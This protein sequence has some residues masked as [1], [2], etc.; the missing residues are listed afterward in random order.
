MSME[1]S[2]SGPGI[3][4]AP[5]GAVKARLSDVL[6]TMAFDES[7]PTISLGDILKALKGK[8]F[9]GLMFVFALP[10]LAPLPP[11][12]ST[13]LGIPLIFLASQLM[14]GQAPWLPAV[15]RK[16]SVG[17]LDLVRVVE[18]TGPWLVRFERLLR[19]RL[20]FLFH[21]P[22]ENLI[23]VVCL[24]LA[25]IL[26]LPV[27]L[28]NLPPAVAICLMS[29]GLVERDGVFVLAGVAAGIVACAA[30]AGA[31]LAVLKGMWLLLE[32]WSG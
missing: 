15:I 21:F 2:S 13:V 29:L 11:G 12:A 17:R 23:G 19:P 10:N 30:A 22:G 7:R 32:H 18:V 28:G 4:A 1:H 24:I 26:S 31:T 5:A 3:G 25:A 9:G 14:T 20:S 16:R 8:A 6:E 27:P